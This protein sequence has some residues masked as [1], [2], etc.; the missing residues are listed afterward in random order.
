MTDGELRVVTSAA[1][2][3]ADVGVSIQGVTFYKLS[4]EQA[5][6]EVQASEQS[7]ISPSYGLRVRAEGNE[8]AV[9]LATTV[10]IG[11]G[12]IVVDAAVTYTVDEDVEVSEAVG[13]EFANEVG[14][15][16]LL[17]YVRQAIA[18]LSQRVFGDV[19]LMPVMA[20]GALWFS[21]EHRREPDGDI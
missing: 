1:E 9:R 19:V 2:L 15:M 20:R 17:P 11:P 6:A 21:E 12:Q 8:I 4:A 10:D 5:E 3:V 18:D 13:L 16:A 14:I 7:E